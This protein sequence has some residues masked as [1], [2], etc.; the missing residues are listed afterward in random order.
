MI[1]LDY[2]DGGSAG[3]VFRVIQFRI[4]ESWKIVSE[5]ELLARIE[6]VAGQ[7]RVRGKCMLTDELIQRIGRNIDEQHFN[8]LPNDLKIHWSQY[9]AEVIVQGDSQ[10][11]IISKPEIDFTRFEKVFRNYI[12]LLVKDWWGICF[13]VYDAEMSTDFEVLVKL[14]AKHQNDC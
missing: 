11:L 3:A 7:W 13:K 6:K 12:T 8:S 5:G 4:G 2:I 10:Y 1:E 9:I 14:G